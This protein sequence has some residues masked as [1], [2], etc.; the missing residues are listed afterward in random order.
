MTRRGKWKIFSI[1]IVTLLMISPFVEAINIS[2]NFGQKKTDEGYMSLEDLAEEMLSMEDDK[3]ME[4]INQPKLICTRYGTKESNNSY[5]NLYR[6]VCLLTSKKPVKITFS[7]G[8]KNTDFLGFVAS[9][10]DSIKVKNN[11]NDKVVLLASPNQNYTYRTVFSLI[12]STEAKE[13]KLE[14]S[15][16]KAKN[17]YVKN[18]DEFEQFL[19]A[20]HFYET[21]FLYKKRY[22]ERTGHE[23]HFNFGFANLTGENE[24][25]DILNALSQE[26]IRSLLNKPVYFQ[27]DDE[28]YKIWSLGDKIKVEKNGRPVGSAT[29]VMY[30][31]PGAPI[32]EAPA[33]SEIT[34]KTPTGAFLYNPSVESLTQST[35]EVK[36]GEKL[37][38]DIQEPEANR[39]T[40]L[41]LK[42]KLESV[43]VRFKNIFSHYGYML[44]A[45]IGFKGKSTEKPKI[46]TFN[47]G[48]NLDGEE[49]VKNIDGLSANYKKATASGLRREI[50]SRW[51]V[52]PDGNGLVKGTVTDIS[53]IGGNWDKMTEF[54]KKEGA[55]GGAYNLYRFTKTKDGWKVEK[56]LGSVGK[57]DKW[58][59]TDELTGVDFNIEGNQFKTGDQLLLFKMNPSGKRI[60]KRV[61]KD[62]LDY[63]KKCLKQMKKVGYDEDTIIEEFIGS[64]IDASLMGLNGEVKVS[65]L[66][67][68]NG[69]VAI[70]IFLF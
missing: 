50:R 16:K 61:E 39:V 69:E 20:V 53:D 47:Y 3:I 41:F 23:A 51:N 59:E 2:Q 19:G 46:Y 32:V 4:F 15:A 40:G 67:N 13:P 58:V 14:F 29:L 5:A 64:K 43:W 38:E 52:I 18:P 11:L 57:I 68:D 54:L 8:N 27:V 6:F 22:E 21:I 42:E 35:L 63:Y 62:A 55:P 30:I 65:K 45:G 34:P 10:P 1:F 60:S 37:K 9:D 66:V 26:E 31:S 44:I 7:L 48:S 33:Y 70:A 17:I 56:A 24:I 49:V 25:V 28:K 12:F 36:E